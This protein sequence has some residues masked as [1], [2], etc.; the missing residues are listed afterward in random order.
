MT[1]STSKLRRIAVAGAVVLAL[2]AAVAGSSLAGS[3]KV[4]Q[5]P[6]LKASVTAA[7]A[8]S[9]R[10]AN[11]KLVKQLRAGWYTITI[12]DD[13]HALDFHIL[14]PGVNHSTGVKFRGVEL[15]GMHVRKGIY[16]FRSD[17]GARRAGVFRVP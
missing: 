1:R 9:L 4:K 7:G 11:G 5:P 2:S 10:D 8:V 14:G 12:A 3:P 16:H 17:P 6:K 13:S 15:W